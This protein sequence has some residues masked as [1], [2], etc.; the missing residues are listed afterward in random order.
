MGGALP[1][2]KKQWDKI[3]SFT[4]TKY[5]EVTSTLPDTV[6]YSTTVAPRNE[7]ESWGHDFNLIRAVAEYGP[8]RVND[9]NKRLSAIEA[10]AKALVDE[11]TTLNA[12]IQVVKPEP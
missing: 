10:E 1:P 12:L 6:S 3:F 7:N 11:R 9:I 2:K 4:P 5:P 8:Q